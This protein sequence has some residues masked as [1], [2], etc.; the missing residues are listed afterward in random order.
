VTVISEVLWPAWSPDLTACDFYLWNSLKDKY[1][2]HTLEELKNNIREE[3]T[4]IVQEEFHSTCE[5]KCVFTLQGMF[6]G[7]Y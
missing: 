5:S 4:K 1:N 2:L 6:T 7:E 3:V